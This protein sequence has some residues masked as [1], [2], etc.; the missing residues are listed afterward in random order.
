[1]TARKRP[2]PFTAVVFVLAEAEWRVV[3]SLFPLAEVMPSPLGQWFAVELLA[4]SDSES[5]LFFHGG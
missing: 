1:M 3:R 4:G 5:V 2:Q